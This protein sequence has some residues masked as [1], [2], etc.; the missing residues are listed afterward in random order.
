VISLAIFN[1][2]AEFAFTVQG[3]AIW[4]GVVALLSVLASILP[5]RSASRLTIREVLAYE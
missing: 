4:L 3:F 1:S 5:A 2:P